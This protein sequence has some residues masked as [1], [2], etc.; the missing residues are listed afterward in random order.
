MKARDFILQTRA[1][2]Q[3]K[4]KEWWKDE[5]LFIKLQRAYVALQYRLPWFT[6]RESLNIEEGVERYRL[7]YD[8]LQNISFRIDGVRIDY[9]EPDYMYAQDG[10]TALYTF[11][12]DTLVLGFIPGGAGAGALVYRHLAHLENAN[13]AIELPR[14]YHDALSLMFKHKIYEKPTRNSKERNLSTHYLNL[15]NKEVDDIKKN[16]PVRAKNTQ[17][18]YKVV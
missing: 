6:H 13:C 10:S 7:R 17:T 5:E 3:E 8:A 4:S 14:E 16:R 18:T 11:E 1:D 9:A 15:F 2:L 12:D